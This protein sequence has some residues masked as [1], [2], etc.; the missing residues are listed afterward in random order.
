MTGPN[1]DRQVPAEDSGFDTEATA[2]P[3]WSAAASQSR[4]FWLGEYKTDHFPTAGSH[5]AYIYN[6]TESVWTHHQNIPVSLGA[7]LGFRTDRTMV[8]PILTGSAVHCQTDSC[9]STSSGPTLWGALLA[10]PGSH[11]AGVL[12]APFLLSADGSLRSYVE[13]EFNPPVAE[14]ILRKVTA[15]DG[16]FQ[17]QDGETANT[18]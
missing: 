9:G 2:T 4:S 3:L 14:T 5:D 6:P 11:R 10:H 18:A 1:N 15:E 8:V 7:D 17:S 16:T 13:D 12:V